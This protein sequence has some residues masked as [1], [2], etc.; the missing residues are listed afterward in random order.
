[1]EKSGF[2]EV[3]ESLRGGRRKVVG[4]GSLYGSRR[5]LHATAKFLT[6]T[7]R[8]YFDS[9]RHLARFL[10]SLVPLRV[11]I[12]ASESMEESGRPHMASV[13]PHTPPADNTFR[14]DSHHK[15]PAATIFS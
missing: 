13:Q 7:A 4:T 14:V 9:Q 2:V 8:T 12:S 10:T 6:G 5:T 11:E 3:T 1:M 15:L